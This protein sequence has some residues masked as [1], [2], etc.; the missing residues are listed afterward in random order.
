M[1]REIDPSTVTGLWEAG[2][3]LVEE[4]RA[5]E[6][7]DVLKRAL[8]QTPDSP[9]VLLSLARALHQ[10]G[11]MIPALQTYDRLI[12]LG[13]ATA[14]VW[15]ETGNALTDVGEYAQAIGAFEQSL[16]LRQDDA[17]TQHNLGRVLYRLGDVGRAVE[18]IERSASL[19]DSLN[20]WAS[21]AT[22]IPGDPLADHAKVRRVR[23]QYA[24]RLTPFAPPIP[25]RRVRPSSR[26]RVGYL[27]A[28]FHTANYMKP[29]WGLINH[30]DRGRFEIHLFSDSPTDAFDGYAPHS[31]DRVH[32]IRGWDNGQVAEQIAAC[33]IDV[34]IDLNAYSHIERLPLFLRSPAPVTAAWFNMYATSGFAGFDYLIGDS[35]VVRP[36][37]EPFYTERV[38]RLPLSYLTFEVLHPAPPVS[39]APHERERAVTFGS[40]VSQYKLTPPVLDAWAEILRRVPTSR[41]LLGN[42]ALRSAQNRAFV[43]EQFVARGI[44]KDRLTLLGPAE[45]YD[46]LTYYDPIDIALDAFPYNGGTTTMEAIWQGVPVVAMEG[47]RWAARTSATLL[48]ETH[49]SAFVAAGREAYIQSAVHWATDPRALA[50]LGNLRREMRDRLRASSACDTRRF[51]AAMESLVA[52]ALQHSN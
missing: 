28:Y 18:H 12:E 43:Q 48:K 33:G 37:E 49:L 7:V 1:T 40:L 6:A 27:S 38:L 15:C 39:P 5:D 19:S 36:S 20:P 23:E 11:Q 52:S 8:V 3:R 26:I 32:Q 45:H 14:E 21:L 51:A 30:H 4:K 47:D 35:H 9:P 41:L 25:R 16:V 44:A 29:V 34:L 46:F 17:E 13:A 24:E 2:K 50:R 42:S 31:S 10:S 22:M